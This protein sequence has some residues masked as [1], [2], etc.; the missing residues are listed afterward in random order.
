VFGRLLKIDL[1]N[2]R[3]EKETIP[4]EWVMDYIGGSGLAARMLWE[5]LD[6]SI[7]PLAPE[8]PLLW[9]TGPLTGSAGPTTGRFTICARSP[10]TGI[11]GESNI[12][13][14]VGPELRFAGFDAMW[15][16][17]KSP[18]PVYLWIHDGE[19]EI[20]TAATYW[21][22]TDTY[23]TQLRIKEELSEPRARVA[24]I[25]L[26]GENQ[27]LYSLILS[28]HG[29]VA[30][31]TGMGAIM[32]SKN[33][34]AVAVRGTGKLPLFNL[35]EYSKLR[36]QANKDLLQQNMTQVFN[37]TGTSGAADYLQMIGDM[38]QKYWTQA[39]FEGSDKVSGAE[40]A[41][42]ILT[43]TTGCQGCVIKC[44]RE[45]TIKD[46][47]YA[48]N[49]TKG[50][51]YET[52]CSFGPQLLVDD[53]AVITA[54]GDRCDRLGVDSISA[55]NTIALSYLMFEKGIITTKDTGGISLVWGDAS[56]CF[57]LLDQIA[58][59]EGFGAQLAL[60]TRNFAKKFDVEDMA[61][62]VN[63]L[64]VAMHDPRGF[65][66]QAIPYV[67]S[68]RGACHNQGDYF[69]IELG[70]SMEELDIPMT[71]R[72][73]DAGKA[74]YIARHQYWRTVCNSLV[75]CFFAVVPVQTV[76]DL[77]NAALGGQ[78]DIPT[79]IKAGERAWNL[80]RLYNGKLGLTRKTEK[81]PRLLLQ[82]LP[83]G[84]QEGHVPDMET[85][86]S[87]YYAV[88]SWDTATGM[89]TEEKQRELGLR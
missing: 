58:K 13:G 15:I 29:R 16:T 71:D 48:G 46:G 21:G 23:D 85:M 83:D 45:V 52:I 60:G 6:P 12:G 4:R 36:V 73:T 24:C 35:A 89:P 44:G 76:C 65:S 50:P 63:N 18:E 55:G 47:P 77:L 61:V 75:M 37:A 11:W 22:Q 78:W 66:G 33:L 84:G 54:L 27:V 56:P 70:G 25:G 26:A 51:E 38:P 1:S 81:L 74:H 7:D 69:S 42:T 64:E 59:K 34:K 41:E 57:E 86:L 49:Q 30:G 72:F 9:I 32:G 14:F 62:Q 87:E 43:G 80:K 19:V 67:T 3:I 31:R 2:N 79:L 8:N 39:T 20:R 5:H 17:G 40:M 10:Q 53:L 88:S 82:S 28:D 68:P